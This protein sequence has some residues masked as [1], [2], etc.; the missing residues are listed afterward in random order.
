MNLLDFGYDYIL[1]A[2][3]NVIFSFYQLEIRGKEHVPEGKGCILAANHLSFLDG[4]L[5][6]WSLRGRL[7]REHKIVHWIVHKRVY[8]NWLFRPACIFSRSVPI[9]GSTSLAEKILKKGKYLGIF[10]QGG[11][12]CSVTIKKGRRGVAV[13]AHKT[14]APVI[15]CRIEGDIDESARINIIPRMFRPLKLTFGKPIQYKKYHQE[16]IPDD[17]LKKSL[18][19]IIHSINTA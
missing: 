14:G 17:M 7:F 16:R 13:L 5:I 2:L 19:E 4:L 8:S 15:P 18:S 3:C 1:R 11:I 6:S 9:N 10:P 12:C